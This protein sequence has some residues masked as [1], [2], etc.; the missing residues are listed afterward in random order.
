M[1]VTATWGVGY[2]LK[3]STRVDSQLLYACRVSLKYMAAGLREV[4]L[5]YAIGVARP[6]SI[7]RK[8]LVPGKVDDERLLELRKRIF[9]LTP[10]G[11][12]RHLILAT[13]PSERGGRFYQDVAAY[14]HFKRT[15]L[16]P[17]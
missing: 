10:L 14:G 2:F 16:D 4:Q 7:L 1:V 3:T 6:V 15:D 11:L 12:F 17:S 5:S 13:L 9:E 8:H